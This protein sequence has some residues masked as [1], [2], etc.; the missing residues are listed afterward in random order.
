MISRDRYFRSNFLTN[1]PV[2]PQN[3]QQTAFDDII[4]PLFVLF[5]CMVLIH[6]PW[7][8]V[9]MM[10]YRPCRIR[11]ETRT[12]D[13]KQLQDMANKIEGGNTTEGILQ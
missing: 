5:L 1:V 4:S 3:Q 7:H 13:K 10:C 11:A 2:C 9:V 8:P 6:P 12:T